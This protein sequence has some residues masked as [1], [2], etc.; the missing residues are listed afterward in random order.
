MLFRTHGT[1]WFGINYVLAVRDNVYTQSW[2][3]LWSYVIRL[4]WYTFLTEILNMGQREKFKNKSVL[5][6]PCTWGEKKSVSQYIVTSPTSANFSHSP[7]CFFILTLWSFCTKALEST[8][9]HM[10]H[11]FPVCTFYWISL[12]CPEN[13]LTSACPVSVSK[14]RV[15]NCIA[16]LRSI[17]TVHNENHL[18]RSAL[19]FSQYYTLNEVTKPKKKHASC[20]QWSSCLLT[21]LWNAFHALLDCF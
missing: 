12:P 13:E 21:K 2:W 9:S 15:C 6:P 11:G 16:K 5:K 10:A 4:F 7:K 8:V 20:F 3:L 17:L 1:W 19:I 18:F 14:H